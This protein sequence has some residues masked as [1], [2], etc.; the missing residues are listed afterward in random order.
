MINVDGI[1]I[2]KKYNKKK[3]IKNC[4]SNDNKSK[5]KLKN[6]YF[7]SL[8]CNNNKLQLNNIDNLCFSNLFFHKSKNLKTIVTLKINNN[9]IDLKYSNEKLKI[10][11]MKSFMTEINSIFLKKFLLKINNNNNSLN[12]TENS[13]SF[14]NYSYKSLNF[15]HSL[16]NFDNNNNNF[17]YNNQIDTYF[18]CD[19]CDKINIKNKIVILPCEHKICKLCFK[20]YFE[21]K[22]KKKEFINANCPFYFCNK[23][24]SNDILKENINIYLYTFFLKY[25]DKYNIDNNNN[26]KLNDIEN[27]IVIKNKKEINDNLFK[28]NVQIFSDKDNL[29]PLNQKIKKEYCSYCFNKS[30]FEI[31]FSNYLKCLNCLK[32]FC[33]YC[34]KEIKKDHYEKFSENYCRMYSIKNKFILKPN[35]KINN[36]IIKYLI[37][38]GLSIINYF[39]I[40]IGIN[41]Y[42]KYIFKKYKL[43]YYLYLLFFEIY[44]IIFFILILPYFPIINLI[45]DIFPYEY[46]N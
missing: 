15:Y 40:F 8:D 34:Y 16:F 35:K 43:L 26:G 21:N 20:Y 2:L 25:N 42:I 18:T 14:S 23:E 1:N 37:N 11:N 3:M 27:G 13:N 22:I 32:I 10:K 7:N 39:L 19:I 45:I 31:P 41:L 24:F 17:N 46:Y 44:L 30:I 29:I 28:K 4:I 9:L 36:E 33:K 38:F 6:N 5:F 12:I